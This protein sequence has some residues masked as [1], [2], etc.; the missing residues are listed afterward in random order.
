M[1]I[2]DYA[3]VLK[4]AI[5]MQIGYQKEEIQQPY[6]DENFHSGVITGLQIALEK[7]DASM[8][9]AER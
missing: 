9:L 6:A 4:W 1:T 8:F 5:Q 3:E 2:K 7:I